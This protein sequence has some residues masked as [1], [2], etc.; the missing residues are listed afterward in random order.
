MAADEFIPCGLPLPDDLLADMLRRLAPRFLAWS[1]CV[2]KAWRDLIDSRRLL[3]A[4]LL[5]HSLAG[6]LLNLN[7]DS[8]DYMFPPF[9]FRPSSATTAISD[10][11]ADLNFS[12]WLVGHC[13]GLLLFPDHVLNPATMQQARLPPCPLPPPLHLAMDFYHDNFLV[14][15]PA[16][17]PHY[18]V[19]LI[20][21]VPRCRHQPMFNLESA[22]WPPSPFTLRV[23]SSKT[24][25]WEER[26]FARQ[27]KPMG[28][29]AD[30]Q[31]QLQAATRFRFHYYSTYH[32]GRLYVQWSNDFVMRLDTSAGTYCIVAPPI[33]FDYHCRL[34]V[35]H[36][37]ESRGQQPEWVLKCDNNMEPLLPC[38]TCYS[39][40]ID[41]PWLLR[42]YN[43][44]ANYDST[45]S[46]CHNDDD[47]SSD[48]ENAPG[49]EYQVSCNGHTTRK[50]YYHQCI[51]TFL[52]FHPYKEAV[53]LHD[54]LQRV[55][56]YHFNSSTIQYVG[57]L[58]LKS[59]VTINTSFSYTPCWL[60]EF[61]ENS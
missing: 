42:S 10:N 12:S 9:F 39:E 44:Y 40:H 5:P 8:D 18:E 57:T 23:F 4:D 59:H 45:V 53:F 49:S 27:G 31:S 6:I 3:R 24:K 16:V 52:G 25:H 15:D 21:R 37:D 7:D 41:G 14:F 28:T 17:S 1:R 11:L 58:K 46:G 48:I 19:F 47:W 32:H 51:E 22:E 35:W 13:N 38:R 43:R 54:A 29:L 61:P 60:G 36:L 33:A 50:S 2:C 56:A 30:V 55:F 20:P 26:S 34:Q